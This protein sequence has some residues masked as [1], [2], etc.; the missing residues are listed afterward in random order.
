M[1]DLIKTVTRS[2]ISYLEDDNTGDVEINYLANKQVSVESDKIK[3]AS[4]VKMKP[5]APRVGFE[6]T[7]HRLTADC[8]A[9]ELPRNVTLLKLFQPFQREDKYNRFR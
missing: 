3:K 8:S 7:T 9:A 2:M 1:E 4:S 6:P 5:F